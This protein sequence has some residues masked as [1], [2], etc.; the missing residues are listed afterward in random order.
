MASAKPFLRWAGGKRW[1]AKLLSPILA[2]RLGEGGTYFEPFLGSGAM[3]FAVNPEKALLSDLN[4]DLVITFREVARKH[5]T[6]LERLKAMPAT[7]KEYYRVREWRPKNTTDRAVRFIYL[8]RNCYGGLYRE[9]KLGV[10]NVPYGGGD[11]N[12][13]YLC[14]NGAIP[15]ATAMLSNPR[16]ELRVY[17]YG[18]VLSL[19]GRG[20]VV[21]CDPTYREVTRKQFDR[22][23]KVI[24]DW[25]DQEKLA[26]YAAEACGRGAVVVLSNATCNGIRDMYRE[27]AVAEVTRRKGLGRRGNGRMQVEYLFILDPSKEWDSWEK[28]GSL[29]LPKPPRKRFGRSIRLGS[30]RG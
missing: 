4:R 30:E 27:A 18:K 5:E 9:N 25:E 17:D 22:Y 13:R 28:V 19:A 10:F 11:R 26:R 3:F 24:F 12:H 15:S 6:I 21:Y 16:I 7:R 8:N 23:G 1:L 14:G 2:S 20:D 29:T